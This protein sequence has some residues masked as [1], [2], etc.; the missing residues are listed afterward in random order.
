MEIFDVQE[1]S[2]RDI[3]FYRFN[4]SSPESYDQLSNNR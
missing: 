1:K 2:K 4:D 3:L